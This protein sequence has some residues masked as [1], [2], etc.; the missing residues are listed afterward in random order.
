MDATRNL[1]PAEVIDQLPKHMAEAL[2]RANLIERCE[3]FGD[4]YEVVRFYVSET[5][6]GENSEHREYIAA[7]HVVTWPKDTGT[8]DASMR[9]AWIRDYSWN[10]GLSDWECIDLVIVDRL[11]MRALKRAGLT[12][13]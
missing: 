7:A 5:Y 4:N 11:T 6:R 3:T 8:S 13:K 1:T 10:R 2:L 9:S 12:S